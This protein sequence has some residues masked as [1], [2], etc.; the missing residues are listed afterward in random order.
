MLT[1]LWWPSRTICTASSCRA[2]WRKRLARY[3]LH[4]PPEPRPASW[5]SGSDARKGVTGSG[6]GQRSTFSA[7]PMCGEDRR[8]A[9]TSSGRSR[10]KTGLPATLARVT[11][12]CRLNLSPAVPRAACASVADDPGPYRLLRHHGQQQAAQ[13]VRP[14]AGADLEEMAYA[15][16]AATANCRG[17]VS[18]PCSPGTRCPPPRS[19]TG[20]PLRERSFCAKNRMREIRSSGS[21]RDGA[22]NTPVY[23]AERQGDR[24][25][26][27]RVLASSL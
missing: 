25:L 20:A 10:R 17:R 23:S 15:D 14:P 18:G 5:T 13:L 19:F 24:A 16:V 11:E 27:S 22:G 6:Q 1:T 21:V 3:G 4:A 9:R 26:W 2:C 12:W 7:S 8:T